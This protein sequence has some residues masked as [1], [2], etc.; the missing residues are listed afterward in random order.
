MKR[1]LC[2]FALQFAF[3]AASAMADPL[4]TITFSGAITSITDP[5]DHFN[6]L[7]TVG[8]S[9]TGTFTYDITT[10]PVFGNADSY[11]IYADGP[12]QSLTF[13]V[14]GYIFQDNG[15]S[16][17]NLIEQGQWV[18]AYDQNGPVPSFVNFPGIDPTA[19]SYNGFGVY[20]FRLEGP[21]DDVTDDSIY[22]P[23]IFA[24]GPDSD[25]VFYV[26][27]LNSAQT[28]DATMVGDVDSFTVT[29]ADEEAGTVPEPST[30]LLMSTGIIALTRRARLR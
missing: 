2:L 15:P 30:I 24:T 21:Y 26:S 16:I 7:F 14:G 11:S 29:S 19:P 25:S 17:G 28:D 27:F 22:D 12:D 6:D 10:S 3:V 4:V 23:S 13:N 5:N 18:E 9:Y 20:A 1:I 8:E